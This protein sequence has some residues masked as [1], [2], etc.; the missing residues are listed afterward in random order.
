MDEL[1]IPKLIFFFILITHLVDIVLIA[2]L[3]DRAGKKKKRA[4]LLG[5]AKSVCNCK[6]RFCL[7]HSWELKG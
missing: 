7:G 5:L 4:P 3:A 2:A 6:E 1:I